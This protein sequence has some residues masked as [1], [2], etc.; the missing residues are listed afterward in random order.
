[1]VDGFVTKG[2]SPEVL[3][4]ELRRLTG[5]AKKPAVVEI[6]AQTIDYLKKRQTGG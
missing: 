6:A 5:G 1:M 3:L 4:G 2:Q